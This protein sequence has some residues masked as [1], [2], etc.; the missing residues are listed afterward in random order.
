MSTFSRE[1]IYKF[2]AEGR[3]RYER[4]VIFCAEFF[5]TR[6]GEAAVRFWAEVRELDPEKMF[7][8]KVTLIEGERVNTHEGLVY[9]TA[10]NEYSEN[11]RDWLLR[12]I[13]RGFASGGVSDPEL[14]WDVFWWTQ[15]QPGKPWLKKAAPSW[16]KNIQKR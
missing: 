2:Q 5:G 8:E 12:S 10:T 7:E 15:V 13:I 16:F 6:S 11:D 3:A 1:T 9:D 14:V 4:R